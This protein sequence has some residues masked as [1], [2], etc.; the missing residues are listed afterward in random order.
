MNDDLRQ[1]P[2]FADLSD[3]QL[4]WLAQHSRTI[5]LGS[6]ETVFAEGTIAD[7]FYVLLDGELQVTANVE[8]SETLLATHHPGAFTGEV[9]LLVGGP[10]IATVRTIQPSCLLRLAKPDFDAMLVACSPVAHVMLPV[11]AQRVAVTQQT[12]QQRDRLA[13]LGKLSAGLAHEL[14]NPAAA[15]R[16]AAA[17]LRET[18]T[19]LQTLT[20]KLDSQQLTAAQLDLLAQ[21]KQEASAAPPLDLDPLAQSDR[22]EELITW[23]DDHEVADSCDLAPNLVRAALVTARLD[24]LAA[25]L[26]AATLGDALLWLGAALDADELVS[27]IETS[28]GRL[29]DLVTAIKGYSFM[30]QGPMQEVDVHQ[31]LDN[32]LTV[33]GFKLKGIVVTREYDHSL[34]RIMAHGGELNQV[35]TNLLDNAA[36]AVGG[37]GHI[38]VR[39]RRENNHLL[40]EIADDGPGITPE[41]KEHIFEPFFTTKE[42]GEGTGLGLSTVY[43]IIVSQHHGDI[44]LDSAPGETVFQVRLPL[45]ESK[46]QVASCK[47]KVQGERDI[48]NKCSFIWKQRDNHEQCNSKSRTQTPNIKS[49]PLGA[50][51][52]HPRL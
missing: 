47:L 46:L 6:G 23:L 5:S 41:V 26:P 40:V 44:C 10:Y 8:G 24:D 4:Q 42:V 25:H 28:V 14:N 19:N 34:P 33:L 35:W 3:E 7:A 38:T 51:R 9:P 39:T 16:R 29:S 27:A 50:G 30:D 20:F 43:N 48:N 2:L 21:L 32:T 37:K 52:H 31:G 15:A 17:Q 36:A 11:L 12:V 1:A 49:G 18:L 13:A 22:E 45:S